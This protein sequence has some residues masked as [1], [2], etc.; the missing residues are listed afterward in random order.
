MSN[1]NREYKDRLFNFTFGREENKEWT[2][3]LY[4]AVNGSN[5]EDASCIE[6]NTLKDVL[7]MGMRNDTSFIIADIMSVYEHQSS[8]NRNM[9]LRLLQYVGDLYSGYITRNKLNKYGKTLINLPTPKLVVFYNGT[10]DQE[11]ETIL[12]LSS[13]FS[14]ST[15]EQSD[16]EVRVRMINVNYGRNK[17]LMNACKPLAEYSWFINEIRKN[18]S[19]GHNLEAAVDAALE[20]MPVNYVIRRFLM[21]HKQEVHGMLDT[22]YNEAE[23]MELF[24][25]DGRKE[26]LEQGLDLHL[27]NLICKKLAKGKDL[28]TIA[29]EVEE[30][31]ERVKFICDIASKHA[32]DYDP[33]EILKQMTTVS[34]N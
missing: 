17:E 13:A 20:E 9:P 28:E 25:E 26:G 10:D 2:L 1:I 33:E 30:P 18:Q 27:I 21:I 29:E 31:L 12:R 24:K 22:E 5:Y 14:E 11:D 7:F 8:F 19:N 15:R 23:V 6:F 16:I 3:S 32:P 4:N 34:V